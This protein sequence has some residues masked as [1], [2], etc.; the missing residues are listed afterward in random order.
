MCRNVL[1][2]RTKM[3]LTATVCSIYEDSIC[4]LD[5]QRAISEPQNVEQLLGACGVTYEMGLTQNQF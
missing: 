1:H 4:L 3:P 2:V 5:E